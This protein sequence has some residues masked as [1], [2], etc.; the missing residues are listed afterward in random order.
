MGLELPGSCPQCGGSAELVGG[1]RVY[2]HRADLHGK[3]FWM[4]TTCE[5]SYVGCHP[6]TERPLGTL[7]TVAIRRARMSAH[8]AFDPL[9][10]SGKMRRKQAYKWLAGEL[11]IPAADCHISWFGVEMCN[12]VVRAVRER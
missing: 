10:R 7:A 4:C 9:W 5:Q 6:G 11:G 8:A 12:S 1:A 2:P 3:R